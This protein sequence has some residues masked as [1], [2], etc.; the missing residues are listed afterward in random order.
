MEN[1]GSERTEENSE[2]KSLLLPE[3]QLNVPLIHA[4][5][6]PGMM[7][8]AIFTRADIDETKCQEIAG[9]S[10]QWKT[11]SRPYRA[12]QYNMVYKRTLY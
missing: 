2:G 6:V 10:L 4:L 12:G 8:S 1:A 3:S 9:I 5:Y 11:G 7:F